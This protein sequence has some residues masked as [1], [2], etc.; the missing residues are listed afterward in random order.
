M[1]NEKIIWCFS[2]V[3]LF[4][5]CL[6]GCRTVGG[7][8]DNAVLEH[9]ARIIELEDRNRALTERL[10]QY[11]SLVERTVQRIEAVRERAAGIGDAA[12]RIDYLFTEYERTVQQLIHELRSTGGTVGKGTKNY[13]DVVNYLALLDRSESFA[14]YCRLHL[15]G[16]Q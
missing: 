10:G 14:D 8:T 1:M 5:V 9:Q 4:V 11:D 13:S 6:A 12:D 2:I 16:Y 3:V 15:A 7:A